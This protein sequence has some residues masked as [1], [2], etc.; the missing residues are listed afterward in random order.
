MTELAPD[1]RTK[2]IVALLDALFRDVLHEEEPIFIS[3]EAT[4][5]DVSLATPDELIRRCSAYYRTTITLA[6]LRTPLWKVLP[7]LEQSR[8][9]AR[10]R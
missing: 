1:H 8:L 2:E 10:D 6:D 5:L 7:G 3:D 9:S 4:L